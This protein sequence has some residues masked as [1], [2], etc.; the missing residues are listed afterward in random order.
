MDALAISGGTLERAA[1][2]LRSARDSVA[3]LGT[4][5]APRPSGPGPSVLPA[6]ARALDV[7]EEHRRTSVTH[8]GDDVDR[9]TD[10]ARAY[11]DADL[12][13]RDRFARLGAGH[14]APRA[15]AIPR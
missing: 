7:W 2:R 11:A 1:E 9:L 4:V 15:G 12:A 8:L 3:G 5:P 14:G 10:S 13:T 6:A